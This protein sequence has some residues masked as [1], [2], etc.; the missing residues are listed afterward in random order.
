VNESLR[1]LYWL[2]WASLGLAACFSVVLH[3]AVRH[4]QRWLRYTAAE[5]G[6][7]IRLGV[8]EKLANASRRFSEGRYNNFALGAIII[9]YILLA[10]ACGTLYLRFK[11]QL[12]AKRPPEAVAFYNAGASLNKSGDY[13]GAVSNFTK[14]IEIFPDYHEAYSFRARA[15]YNL[16]DYNGAIADANQAIRLNPAYEPAYNVRGFS[17]F[18]LNDYAGAI[19]EF[20]KS[21]KLDS[22]YAP[23]FN[24]RGL[25]E[26]DLTNY[27]A[28]IG[29]FNRAIKLKPDYAVAYYDRGQ[30]EQGL[31]N[32]PAAVSDFSRAIESHADFP[33]AF[34]MRG[35]TKWCLRD[36][37]GTITDCTEAIKLN[38]KFWE[39][40]NNRGLAESDLGHYTAA[41]IDFDKAIALNPHCEIAYYNRGNA[42]YHL[43]DWTAA[44]SDF[45][46]AIELKPDDFRPYGYL[47]YVQTDLFQFEAALKTFQKALELDPSAAE[48]RFRIWALRSRMNDGPGATD[49]LQNYLRSLKEKTMTW[50]AAVGWY[51]VGAFSERNFLGCAAKSDQ[52]T[53]DWWQCRA[54]Y[55]AGMKHLIAGDKV[56]AMDFFQQSLNTGQ[57]NRTE[58]ISAEV[59]LN[60]LK[61]VIPP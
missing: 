17:R 20:D 27:P 14:A 18:M 54:N 38:P 1:H 8:P 22:T 9:T 12:P 35:L 13:A 26:A 24:Q 37:E 50:P 53:R 25:A 5:A 2:T 52:K 21:L 47:G 6:F 33:T 36:Y 39:A 46:R 59:E 49:E 30:V 23:A 40:Y 48:Y 44:V 16:E 15:K 55:Y 7:W 31:T 10:V 11:H 28:A 4:R 45:N 43:R 29:D 3:I 56:G 42:R 58:Y 34:N 60:A 57:T 41:I 32:Y 19:V 51:L 61:K